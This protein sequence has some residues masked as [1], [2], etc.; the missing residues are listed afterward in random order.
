MQAKIQ[1]NF[2]ISH[3]TKLWVKTLNKLRAQQEKQNVE[4]V[5]SSTGRLTAFTFSFVYI[6]YFFTEN[7]RYKLKANIYNIDRSRNPYAYRRG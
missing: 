3:I 7:P 6:Q 1:E 5:T 2:I 4:V